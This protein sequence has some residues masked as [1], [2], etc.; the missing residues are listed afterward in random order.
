[1]AKTGLDLVVRHARRAAA[2]PNRDQ[3]SDPELL[4]R[5]LG[6]ADPGAF[7]AVVRRHGPL[8]MR[9]CRHVLGHHQDAEDAFQ[10]TFLVLARRAAGIRKGGSLASWLHGVAYRTALTARRRAATRRKHEA[11]APTGSQPEAPQELAWR[12]VQAILEEEVE[13]LPEAYRS[14]FVLCDMEGRSR[15]EAARELGVK[16]G[17]L[18]SRL[19]RARQRLRQ[20]LQGRGVALSA[21]LGVVAVARADSGA[22]PRPLLETT[23]RAGVAYAAGGESGGLVPAGAAALVRAASRTLK[24]TPGKVLAAVLAAALLVSGLT[25]AAHSLLAPP[26]GEGPAPKSVPPAA[27]RAPAPAA[28]A[29]EFVPVSGRVLGPDGKP[30]AGAK[31]YVST[32]SAKD[33]ADP[34][35]RATSG[36]DGRFRFRA[37]RPEVNFN[38]SVAAVAPGLGPNWVPLA[39]LDGS[40]NLPELRLVPEVPVAGRVLDLENAPVADATVRLVRVRKMPDEDLSPWVK[41]MQA[42]GNKGLLDLNRSRV[43]ISYERILKPV[44]GVLG[45]PRSVKTGPDGRFRL[46]GFGR[47]RIV[48]L[49][50]EGPGLE[51]RQVSV[52]TRAEAPPGIPPLIY[53]A[54]FEHRAA[55]DKPIVGT[56]REKG[57]G[58]PVAGA[59]VACALVSPTGALTDVVPTAGLKTTTDEQGRYRL[60]G[61]PKS[62]QYHLAAVAGPYFATVQV[63]ND[64]AGLGPV[65]S[66]FELERG[67]VVRGRLTDR[68]TGRPGPGALYY[69]PHAENPRLKDYPGFAKYSLNATEPEKDGSFAVAVVPGAGFLV[70]RATEDRYVRG[71]TEGIRPPLPVFL[72][73][74]S[75]HAVQPVDISD[76][77]PKS[78]V[79]DIALDPGR[80]LDGTVLGPN[81]SPL[82]GAFAA[83][84]TDAASP[85]HGSPPKVTLRTPAFT[86]VALDPR[87]PRS[88]VFW[89]E[90]K[91]LARA[92]LVRGDEPGPLKVRLEPLGTVTGLLRNAEGKPAAG[93]RV[94]VRYSSGQKRALP[95][96]LGEGIPGIS[97]PALTLPAGTTDAEGRFRLAGL[98]PG[99]KYDLFRKGKDATPLAEDFSV[100]G[101]ESKDL[102][103]VRAKAAPGK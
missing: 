54:S 96:E 74:V 61:A 16:D 22:V 38:E 10:A 77:D 101:G 102:G 8:V 6:G 11:R 27:D 78:Q 39:A 49:L 58:K 2:G 82:G 86:A 87:R 24:L 75:Y 64:T 63:V 95:D 45:V 79:C 84:L 25:A 3:P 83:G 57:T 88:L 4:G 92:V 43:L 26:A 15:E 18:S 76:K 1:M 17:T 93:V 70:A 5:F 35:V 50:I 7:T 99:M 30:V 51:S 73:Y 72:Q 69:L 53:G 46:A 52:I 48:E 85:V 44:W 100:A 103:E 98:V 32:Y 47:E 97:K 28:N 60:R 94:E 81:G 37:A 90:E 40:G 71:R 12:E 14:P 9:V 80:T 59:E 56:V 13:A 91:K 66:D 68:E 34:P 29:Q 42:A 36:P 55:P 65:A 31:V 23:A 67:V 33:Q 62:K 89:Q 20:R 19:N 41:D 21:L